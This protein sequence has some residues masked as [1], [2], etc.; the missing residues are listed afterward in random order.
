MELRHLRYFLAVSNERSFTRA[1]AKLGVS[2]PPLSRQIRELEIELGTDL[3]DRNS[4]PLR[5]TEAGWLFYEQA[6]QIMAGVEQMKTLMRRYTADERRRFV[7][8]CVGSTIYGVV[9]AMIVRFRRDAPNVTV[10]LVEMNTLEQISAL[11]EGRIDVGIG[12]LRFEREGVRRQVVME[13]PFV[14]ALPADHLLADPNAAITLPALAAETLVV[15]PRPT[16]PS[17]ADQVLSVFHDQDLQPRIVR[18]V[19]ELQ[20]ALG[21][22]AAQAGV[23]VVP[24]SVQR[25][26]RDDVVYRPIIDCLATSPII[27]S[28]READVSAEMEL[29]RAIGHALQGEGRAVA[30]DLRPAVSEPTAS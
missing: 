2:Q 24:A 5:L 14:V 17:Y 29:F 11:Q 18:E 22:V 30:T 10:D 9:P 23:C 28:T 6:N 12:R 7:I 16:R 25:L 1:A 15:Y 26:R 4:R 13:E 20:T 19:R 27:I 3:L 8:G 21:L